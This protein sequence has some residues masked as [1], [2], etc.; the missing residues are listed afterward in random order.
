M[1]LTQYTSTIPIQIGHLS[2]H[3]LRYAPSVIIVFPPFPSDCQ[4]GHPK[5]P[6]KSSYIPMFI[7]SNT[8]PRN[9]NWKQPSTEFEIP[10]H[11]SS[12]P[13]S[14]YLKLFVAF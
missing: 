2:I 13:Y 10:P 4:I 1:P 11:I 7:K 3:L 9:W 12:L 6:L 5:C 14:L 8:L